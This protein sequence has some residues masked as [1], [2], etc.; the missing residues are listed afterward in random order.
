MSKLKNNS[1]ITL[2][3]LI[4]T[5]IVLLIL[6]MVSIKL[7]MNG[8]IID[9][10][11]RGTQAY[12]D[13]E[14]E[15][16]IKTAYAEYQAA[17]HQ[18]S[19]TMEQALEHSG[20]VGTIVSGNDTE[21]W[22]ITYNGKTYPLSANGT[23]GEP[24]LSWKKSDSMTYTNGKQILKAGDYVN[25]DPTDGATEEQMTYTSLSAKSGCNSNQEFD[26]RIYKNAGYKWKI[27]DVKDGKIRLISE[28]PVG[29]GNYSDQNR[30]KYTLKGEKGF[31]NGI[32]ELNNISEIFGYGAGAE[33]SKSITVEDINNITGYNPENPRFNEGEYDEYGNIYSYTVNR[34]Q[35]Y[36][37]SVK[38]K[39]RYIY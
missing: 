36:W 19:I 18:D 13:A 26:A 34:K 20:L 29:S 5:I 16:K 15:E 23:L 3:A 28:E 30:T 8:G 7:V 9:R 31:T 38:W 14:V 33:S 24:L 22:K 11:Q 10:A 32:N 17:K 37:Y 2:V 4:I 21:G 6:A 25:Y 35:D 27:L 1:G 39:N 12:S